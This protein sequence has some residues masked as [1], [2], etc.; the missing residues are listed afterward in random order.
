[1]PEGYAIEYPRAVNQTS[2]F[3]EYHST[4]SVKDSVLTAHRELK[5]KK[6]AAPRAEYQIFSAAVNGDI[7]QF[8]QLHQGGLNVTA[9][10]Y[11]PRAQALI[12]QAALAIRSRDFN[13][14]RDELTQAE[15]I[16]P[17]QIGLWATYAG[18]YAETSQPD[19]ALESAKKEIDLHPGQPD[20]YR[21][22]AQLQAAYKHNDDAIVSWQGLVKISP[23]DHQGVGQLSDLLV[24]AGRFDEALK[25]MQGALAV[26]PDDI[27]IRIQNVEIL[28]RADKK[29]EG[30]KAAEGLPVALLNADQLNSV[31]WPLAEARTDLTLAVDYAQRSVTIDEATLS[32]VG[33]STLDQKQL[34]RTELLGAE[35]DTLGWALFLSEDF[36]KA[37]KYL[38]ASWT[39]GQHG[40]IADH[41]G[42]LYE[43]Q[44]KKDAAIRMW[45]LALAADGSLDGAR[46]RLKQA[47]PP[48]AVKPGAIP[49]A[50]QIADLSK[51]R[52]V[53]VSGF[54]RPKGT[55]EFFVLLSGK[56]I[57][58]VSMISGAEDFSTAKAAILKASFD[59]PIP[60]DGPE[61]IARRGILSCSQYTK[62]NCQLVLMLPNNT[63]VQ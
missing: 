14:A 10:E 52:T 19:K 28:V 5:I 22:L 27:D 55:A 50:A 42:Q 8:L 4:Y 18:L 26:S 17:N 38:L 54:S 13:S 20:L 6:S 43:K 23:A 1:L 9:S 45:K 40:V 2:D 35:W 36:D 32:H 29:P 30:S 63:K 47:E 24:S 25:V 11:D 33:L 58:D 7:D 37:E 56:G 60:D 15:H 49:F 21:W 39:L 57:E 53:D 44:G 34:D 62:P 12:Q 61:K 3:A 51:M 59:M 48:Q 31:A 46:D 16:N 41:L